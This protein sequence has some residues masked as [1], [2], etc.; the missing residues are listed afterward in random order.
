MHKR[1]LWTAKDI[2]KLSPKEWLIYNGMI[3][4]YRLT[5]LW[6]YPIPASGD[7]ETMRRI[8]VIYWLYKAQFPVERATKNS[9]LEAFFKKQALFRWALP[10]GFKPTSTL[11]LSSVGDLMDHPYLP[12]SADALYDEVSELIFGADISMA[13][14]ECVIYPQASASFTIR[15]GVSPPLHYKSASFSAIKGFC[16]RN[17][18][19]MATACNHSLDCGEE[20][21]ASTINT[22]RAEGIAFN[23]VN[24]SEQDARA[25]TIIER[26][27]FRIGFISYTFGLNGKKPP[28]DKPWIVNRAHLTKRFEDINFTQIENQVRYCLAN[29]VDMT[30]AQLHWGMEHEYYP[31]PEQLKIAHYL[32]EL[33][34]D[35]VIGHHPHVVQPVEYYQTWRDPDRVV[36]IYYSLGNLVTPFSHPAFRHSHVAQI[37]LA[38]GITKG[39]ETRT[40]VELANTVEVFQVIDESD[41][42]IRIVKKDASHLRG[43]T[44][45]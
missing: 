22:L 37:K 23:G 13:N 45:W 15:P 11:Q 7:R 42:K 8:D 25:A 44:Q 32:A 17:Y 3:A 26:G 29:K 41:E 36:P 39:G 9:G 35:I 38:K 20:G 31:R 19:F 6:R 43:A 21:V 4:F 14:L 40:Y 34:F 28:Q 27:G 16:G 33:G 18:S 1:L 10:H 30:V 5:G 2:F 12:N 24:E